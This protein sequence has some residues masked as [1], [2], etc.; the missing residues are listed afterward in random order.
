PDRGTGQAARIAWSVESLDFRLRPLAAL[1]H[2]E[3]PT[4]GPHEEATNDF[5]SQALG[6]GHGDCRSVRGHCVRPGAGDGAG[7][8]NASMGF[9]AWRGSELQELNANRGDP[10]A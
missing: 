1:L 5:D 6:C 8:R 3:G 2:S 9:L 7:R 4:S 10:V